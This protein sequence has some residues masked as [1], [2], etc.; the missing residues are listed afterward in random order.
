MSKPVTWIFLLGASAA[1][2]ASILLLVQTKPADAA[3]R[4]ALPDPTQN[5]AESG[6]GKQTAVFAGGCF[7]GVEAVFRHT[8]GVLSA[9]S[10]YAGGEKVNPSYEQVS[11]GRTG[12]A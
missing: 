8:R 11:A 5:I 3:N 10:G 7:W 12:H 9:T 6:N 2:A 1:L 4:V